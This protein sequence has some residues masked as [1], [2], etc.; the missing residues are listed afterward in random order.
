MQISTKD[1]QA[2]HNLY[3]EYKEKYRGCPQDYFP[4]HYIKRRHK[5]EIEEFAHQVAFG[6]ND[7][8]IDAYYIDAKAGNLYLYQA[9]WSTNHSLFVK[10]FE[11]LTEHGMAR[12]FGNAKQDSK[13]ND[14]LVHLARDLEEFRNVIKN[15]YVRF[16]F[17]GNTEEAEK[18]EGLTYRKEALEAKRHLVTSYFENVDV[19]LIVEFIGDRPSLNQTKQSHPYRVRFNGSGSANHDGKTMR[20]GFVKLIDLYRIYLDEELRFFD[21]NIRAS[22][23]RD[24]A[25]NRKIASALESIVMKGETEPS[26]FCFNH[27]GVTICAERVQATDDGL[28]LT[29][30]RLLNGAQT[31]STLA[32]LAEAK[33]D[34]PK[35][36]DNAPRL[37][38]IEVIA[39]IIEDEPTASFITNVTIANNQQNPVMPWQLRAMDKIQVDLADKF[40]QAKVFYSRQ[41]GAFESMDNAD[42]EE[43]EVGLKDI[44]IQQLARTFLAVQGEIPLMTAMPEVFE[45]PKLYAS[46][47]KSGYLHEDVHKIILLYKVGLVI[48]PVIKH[49]RE[50][51]ANKY[52]SDVTVVRYQS[53]VARG[54]NLVQALLIQGLLNDPAL[55]KLVEEY[56]QDLVRQPGFTATLK[57]LAD[58]F[59]LP[60]ITKMVKKEPFAEKFKSER[61]DFMRGRDAFKESM[62]LLEESS[63]S[64]RSLR[65]S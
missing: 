28:L 6:G 49:M 54:K 59:I 61:F 39:K 52:S 8:G 30:P 29:V 35:W 19:R 56:G 22:I 4:I 12:I 23:A 1:E 46:T 33:K 16:L 24:T 36:A 42:R 53:A 60:A 48:N 10:S 27:N 34:N 58:R 43:L 38:Q 17:K 47:F 7:Y 21:R 44:G 14:M 50:A 37:E 40:R 41:E 9:K 64:K 2:L 15:V 26:E 3:N 18:S 63:W 5:A 25:P 62:R 65:T 57:L 55:P 32:K 31:V 20:V 51:I 45:N 11:R 13:Q